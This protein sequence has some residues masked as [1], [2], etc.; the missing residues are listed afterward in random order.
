MVSQQTWP[1]ETQSSR[2]VTA[3]PQHARNEDLHA[4]RVELFWVDVQPIASRTGRDRIG[5]AARLPD[6][7]EIDVDRFARGRRRCFPPQVVD[8]PL[9]R[10]ELVRMQE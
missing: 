7:R 5:A 8:E 4:A 2:R 3:M 9:A 1:L 6:L 10:D